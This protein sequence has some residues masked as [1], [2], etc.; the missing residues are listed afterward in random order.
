MSLEN[1]VTMLKTLKEFKESEIV[2]TIS[3]HDNS[4]IMTVTYQLDLE[5]FQITYVDTMKVEEFTD[6]SLLATTIESI[7]LVE[8]S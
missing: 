2:H 7:L 8:S 5:R 3:D 1:I 4:P 6:I